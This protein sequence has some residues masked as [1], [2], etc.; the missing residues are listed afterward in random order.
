MLPVTDDYLPQGMPADPCLPGLVAWQAG[1]IVLKPSLPK[2]KIDVLSGSHISRLLIL[3]Y[4]HFRESFPD[5]FLSAVFV[6]GGLPCLTISFCAPLHF[7]PG[8]LMR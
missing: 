4:P 8:W 2:S 5:V 6:T 1:E 3:F 7:L